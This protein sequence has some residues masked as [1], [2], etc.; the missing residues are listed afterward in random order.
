[1]N[2]LAPVDS[3]VQRLI[4]AEPDMPT[5][6]SRARVH[7]DV[8]RRL[9][10]MGHDAFSARSVSPRRAMARL[11]SDGPGAGRFPRRA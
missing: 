9:A 7:I 6:S 10:D 8:E 11:D 2:A 1:V 4:D 3:I 5:I